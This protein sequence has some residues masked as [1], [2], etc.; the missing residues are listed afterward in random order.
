MEKSNEDEQVTSQK[1]QSKL[2]VILTMI[3]LSISAYIHLS[4]SL[5]ETQARRLANK[6]IRVIPEGLPQGLIYQSED[7]MEYLQLHKCGD[8]GEAYAAAYLTTREH[9][10]YQ[11][12]HYNLSMVNCEMGSF[13]MLFRGRREVE[14][15]TIIMA[16]DVLDYSIIHLSA[17]ERLIRRWKY[18]LPDKEQIESVI[19]SQKL[20]KNLSS[21]DGFFTYRPKKTQPQ[22]SSRRLLESSS[23]SSSRSSSRSS[24]SSSSSSSNRSSSRRSSSSS[25]SRNRILSNVSSPLTERSPNN[26]NIEQHTSHTHTHSH[27]SPSGS[28]T[29]KQRKLSPE[30]M[31]KLDR[32]VA[33]MPFLGFANGAGH[34]HL[35]NRFEYLIACVYSLKEFYDHIV[36]FVKS[37]K[38]KHWVEQVSGL[39]VWKVVLLDNLPKHAA[40]PV[41]T[42]Q[43]TKKF[44]VSGEWDFDYVYFT[45]SDQI[46]MMRIPEVLYKHMDKYPRRMLLPHRLMPY[47]QRVLNNVHGRSIPE[48]KPNE[49]NSWNERSCCLQ[50]DACQ[51][52]KAF[53]HIGKSGNGG[54]RGA[55]EKKRNKPSPHG[56]GVGGSAEK[57]SVQDIYGLQVPLGNTNFFAETYRSCTM[58]DQKV[59]VCP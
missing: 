50:R 51:G 55:W 53:I 57:V 47:P 33:V 24:S 16:L 42:V 14:N 31:A 43:N 5:F 35:N 10:Q 11:N 21:S 45:E 37:E 48:I 40:L 46:L 27:T 58:Y 3:F 12:T 41:A 38:D 32:T 54:L 17:Y 36:I 56:D 28:I 7:Q 19:T 20:L 26:N 4:P 59:D 2:A 23:S 15:A 8:M 1:T 44:I 29:Y 39:P 22:S 30:L 9:L 34:S 18:V 25:R 52:R 13:I 49:W 6:A